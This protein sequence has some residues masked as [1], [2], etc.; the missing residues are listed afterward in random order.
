ML[1]IRWRVG[2]QLEGR[3]ERACWLLILRAPDIGPAV[4]SRLLRHFSSASAALVAGPVG[5]RD[6]AVALK[7]SSI[8]FLSNPPWEQVEAELEWA[9]QHN[10]HIVMRGEPEYPALLHETSGPPPLLYVH[11][12][13]EALAMPQLAVVG[14]RNPSPGGT[15]N[16]Y[17]FSHSLA[18]SGLCITSGLAIGVDSAA[19]RGALAANGLTVAVAGTGLDRVY[20]ASNRELA[21]QIADQGALVSEFPLGSGVRRANFPRR[22]RVLSGLSVGTLVVEATVRSG[23]LITARLAMEQGREVL[24]IPG[25]IHNPLARGCHR[26]LRDGAK[27]VETAEDVLEELGP[28]AQLALSARREADKV[29]G[30]VKDQAGSPPVASAAASVSAV[31]VAASAVG[32]DADYL[33]LLNA[34]GYDPSPVDLLVERSGLTAEAVSSMLL[35]L[36]LNGSIE[37]MPG[38]LY[39][40]IGKRS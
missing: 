3:D 40:R 13:I 20:P 5:W 19:H 9:Q 32:E 33:L 31:D 29:K 30:R 11:G 8:A 18:A 6:P 12:L 35:I 16:A 4:F 34:M 15:D 23:S 39:S 38:G 24:A 2:I 28:L 25:S 36:E 14:S 26:L 37:A 22:N 1:P 7:A 27:L 10:N 21:H 17:H